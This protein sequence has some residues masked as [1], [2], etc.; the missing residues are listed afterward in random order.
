MT[1]PVPARRVASDARIHPAAR[2]RVTSTVGLR[3]A[4]DHSR[5]AAFA[6]IATA[7][8]APAT[9]AVADRHVPIPAVG[10]STGRR[11]RCP[12]G[13][14]TPPA[15]PHQRGRAVPHAGIAFLPAPG[16]MQ[17]CPRS[18][19]RPRTDADLRTRR[20]A[21]SREEQ[22]GPCRRA[23]PSHDEGDR[24][25]RPLRRRIA[26]TADARGVAF[27][28][29]RADVAPAAL[30]V[31]AVCAHRERSEDPSH[32]ETRDPH[33]TNDEAQCP[34]AVSAGCRRFG[35]RAS[36]VVLM[37]GSIRRGGGRRRR[38]DQGASDHDGLTTI[39]RSRAGTKCFTTIPAPPLRSGTRDRRGPVRRPCWRWPASRHRRR[40]V[41]RG[42]LSRWRP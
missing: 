10:D 11:C 16:R 18:P 19:H 22:E 2:S 24:R 14:C 39:L 38:D 12:R 8:G 15:R 37:A 40:A 27:T 42:C 26:L 36:R 13:R 31:A 33:A 5:V 21:R 30:L 35:G 6:R 23:Y 1:H 25:D 34:L 20:R 32:H 17:N 41:H 3:S 4:V 29:G 28:G 7:R 9:G